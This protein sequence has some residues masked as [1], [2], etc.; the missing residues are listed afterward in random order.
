MAIEDGYA[1]ARC[2]EAEPNISDAFLCYE[3]MRVGR[4]KSIVDGSA[5]NAKRFHNPLLSDA[6]EAVRYVE[7][8][9]TPE[10]VR[11]WYDWLFGYDA[12]TA[13]I[14]VPAVALG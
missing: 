11:R 1:L 3:R 6:N 2:V 12:T 4:T 10:K 5:A 13:P 7:S 9:W 14:G 8:E